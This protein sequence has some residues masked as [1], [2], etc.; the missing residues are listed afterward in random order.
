MAP[1]RAPKTAFLHRSAQSWFQLWGE[2]THAWTFT[3]EDLG[4]SAEVIRLARRR[5]KR[6]ICCSD[7]PVGGKLAKWWILSHSC[8]VMLNLDMA[9]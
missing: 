8:G 4:Q 3:K 6:T 2:L 5:N 7:T 9:S 1:A